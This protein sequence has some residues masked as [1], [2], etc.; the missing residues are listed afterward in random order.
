MAHELAGELDVT[1]WEALLGAVRRAAWKVAWLEQKIAEA[2]DDEELVGQ[3]RLAPFVRMQ[4]RQEQHLA[5]VAKM[6]IDGG[7][8]ER[9]VAQVEQDGRAIGGVLLRTL[10]RLGLE[11]ALGERAR[12]IL[13]QELLALDAGGVVEGEWEEEGK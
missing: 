10:E 7:V 3:G 2:T 11:E 4:E 13:R 12:G 6:A 9:Y 1:P 5:R 8:A